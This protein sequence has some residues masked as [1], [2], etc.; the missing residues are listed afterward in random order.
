VPDSTTFFPDSDL[1]AVREAIRT[2]A[3]RLDT[4]EAL[5]ALA[6]LRRQLEQCVE[7]A[8]ERMATLARRQKN[9]EPVEADTDRPRTVQELARAFGRIGQP[10]PDE[11]A[12][13]GVDPDDYPLF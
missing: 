2:A 3:D 8:E 9:L 7:L 1:A 12:S 4:E 10:V 5:K 13:L 11:D 6:G